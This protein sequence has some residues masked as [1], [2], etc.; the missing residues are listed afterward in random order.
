MWT[1]NSYLPCY[2]KSHEKQFLTG[3]LVR[4]NPSIMISCKFRGLP[5]IS[6][7]AFEWKKSTVKFKILDSKY[8]SDGDFR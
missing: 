2:S 5:N 1:H 4:K 3:I 6:D 7:G 8:A